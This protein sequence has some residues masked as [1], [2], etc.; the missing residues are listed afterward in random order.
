MTPR[1]SWGENNEIIDF[2]RD[3]AYS[4]YNWELFYHVPLFIAER[5][6]QNQQFEDA[7]TWFQY[8]FNPTGRAPSRCRSA[9]GSRSR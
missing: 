3:A 8:I 7:V 9:S 1:V 6:S 2:A 4:V 5:L